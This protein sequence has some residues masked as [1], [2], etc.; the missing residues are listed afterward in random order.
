MGFAGDQPAVANVMVLG[1]IPFTAINRLSPH[2]QEFI[3]VR[4]QWNRSKQECLPGKPGNPKHRIITTPQAEHPKQHDPQLSG[5]YTYRT[6]H[7]LGGLSWGM[8]AISTSLIGVNLA[9]NF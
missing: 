2:V 4:Q 6:E 3:Q 5:T 7:H 1:I 9:L 8:R